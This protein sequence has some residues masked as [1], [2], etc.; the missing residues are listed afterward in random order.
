MPVEK[1][2]R[3]FHGEEGYNCAQAVAAAFSHIFNDDK[4]FIEK[5]QS[6][7]GGRAKDGLCGALFAAEVIAADKDKIAVIHQRFLDEVGAVTC[8]EIKREK[9]VPC[10]I[11]VETAARLLDEVLSKQSVM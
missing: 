5:L 2:K 3:F 7:G 4:S 6:S 9:H 8:R 10:I 1:S 11:C